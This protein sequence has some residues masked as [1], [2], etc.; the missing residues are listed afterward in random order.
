MNPGGWARAVALDAG[1]DRIAVGSGTGELHVRDVRTEQFVGHLAGHAGRV[2][3]LAFTDDPDR[4]VSAA[5]DGTVRAWS[6]SHQSQLAEVR[7]DAS[8]NRAA[9]G[10]S[11]GAVLVGS[12]AGPASLRLVLGEATADQADA[13]PFADASEDRRGEGRA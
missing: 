2:L 3:M 1:G 4:L 7:V 11:T 6:L 10:S 13:Y 5:A 8:L 12:A 9:A